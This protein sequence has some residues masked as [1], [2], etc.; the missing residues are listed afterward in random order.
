MSDGGTWKEYVRSIKYI[1]FRATPVAYG[2]SQVRGQIRATAVSLHHSSQQRQILHPLS[3]ARDRT[4]ILMDT[5]WVPYPLHHNGNSQ[6]SIMLNQPD[7]SCFSGRPENS[8]NNH[9]TG[10]ITR[11]PVPSEPRFSFAAG[12]SASHKAP[13]VCSH[14]AA[15]LGWKS[16]QQWPIGWWCHNVVGR[17]V[18]PSPKTSAGCRFEPPCLAVWCCHADT[19]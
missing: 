9:L 16:Q 11:V 18:A 7:L 10:P 1:Y 12:C 4:H 3:E 15:C 6:L 14:P 2:S 13:S 8:K 17:T 5:S 19:P